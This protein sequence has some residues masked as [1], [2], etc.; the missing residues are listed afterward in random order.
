MSIEEHEKKKKQDGKRARADK[1]YVLE[2]LFKA[3]E[4]HQ[5]YYLKDLIKITQ[6][7]VS[8]GLPATYYHGQ[9]DH[10]EKKENA[11]AWLKG[12]ALIMCA[13]SAFGVGIDKSDVRFVDRNQLLRTISPQTADD[14]KDY[15]RSS[16]NAVISYCMSSICRRQ[17]VLEHF[18]EVSEVDCKNTCDNCTNPIPALRDYTNEA[19]L[20][21][22]CVQEMQ[23]MTPVISIK[24]VA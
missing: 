15:L 20:I 3:F 10:F 2:L 19:K 13:T 11:K 9:L 14:Q 7:P 5:Y 16:V 8:K 24:Q 4:R 18:G 21:C 12:K 17:Y 23:T 1:D 6:Q 22:K